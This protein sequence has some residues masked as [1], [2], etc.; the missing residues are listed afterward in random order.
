MAADV[1]RHPTT[2]AWYPGKFIGLALARATGVTLSEEVPLL[3]APRAA[4]HTLSAIKQGRAELITTAVVDCLPDGASTRLC[5]T[6]THWDFAGFTFIASKSAVGVGVFAAVASPVAPVLVGAATGAMALSSSLQNT[7]NGGAGGAV[8]RLAVRD[9]RFKEAYGF[10]PDEL[11]REHV[12]V[13]ASFWDL[14]EG[15]TV[16]ELV[17]KAKHSLFASAE[18]KE[19]GQRRLL[20]VL[21]AR[22]RGHPSELQAALHRAI[23]RAGLAMKLKQADPRFNVAWQLWH[24]IDALAAQGALGLAAVADGVSGSAKLVAC[25]DNAQLRPRRRE[26]AASTANAAEAGDAQPDAAAPPPP[27]PSESAALMLP[28]VAPLVELSIVPSA[29][30]PFAPR[31]PL[32]ALSLRAA[33][34]ATPAAAPAAAPATSTAV[35]VAAPPPEKAVGTTAALAAAAGLLLA[36]PPGV[37]VALGATAT[38]MVK[39]LKGKRSARTVRLRALVEWTTWAP[40]LDMF[41]QLTDDTASADVEGWKVRGDAAS[42]RGPCRRCLRNL[43]HPLGQLRHN[44]LRHFEARRLHEASTQASATHAATQADAAD[45]N[46]DD[47]DSDVAAD[48]HI[49]LDVLHACALRLCPAALGEEAADSTRSNSGGESSSSPSYH[50]TAA[51]IAAVAAAA[52]VRAAR[53]Q[54]FLAVEE[55]IWPRRDVA[56]ASLLS[57]ARAPSLYDRAFG[58]IRASPTHAELDARFGARRAAWRP[59]LEARGP[60]ALGAL[61]ALGGGG[62][63]GAAEAEGEGEGESGGAGADYVGALARLAELQATPL[64][65]SKVSAVCAAVAALSTADASADVLLPSLMHALLLSRLAAPNAECAFVL[66]FVHEETD[67]NGITGYSLV[68]FQ[69]AINAVDQLEEQPP[70][71]DPDPCSALRRCLSSSTGGGG[72]VLPAIE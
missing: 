3:E 62:G 25:A 1:V 6:L 29:R 7:I 31:G 24:A 19:E 39:G 36:G 72:S 35:V 14:R 18:S 50:A 40:L 47:G 2:D 16:L 10:V 69:A 46:G 49:T 17:L 32:V 30:A 71:T 5:S 15:D 43:T 38:S 11:L 53:A 65:S 8:R 22:M 52:A 68:T 26:S 55:E 51:A 58:A 54:L 9:A 23:L 44:L 34:A 64:P 56:E 61:P 67:L 21:L 37:L 12:P 45:A 13:A 70:A 60:A 41:E 33:P 48:V 66:E 63:G 20:T 28:T 27:A 59:W 57:G 42:L 4:Q